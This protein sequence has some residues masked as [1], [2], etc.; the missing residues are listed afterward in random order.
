MEFELLRGFF[1]VLIVTLCFSLFSQERK[2]K[3]AVMEIEDRSG[4][5]SK[6]IL[7]NAAE[8]LRSELAA[9]N[10]YVLISKDRQLKAM[11]KVEKKESY[12]ECYDQ[13]CRIQLG[14]ALSADTVTYSTI[15]IFGGTYTIALEMIDLAKEAT[16]DAAKVEFNGTE[17]GLKT[18]IDGIVAQIVRKK[19]VSTFQEGRTSEKAEDWEVGQGEETIV[20]FKT[21]PAEAVVLVDGRMLC[22]KTPCS[23]MLSQGKHEVTIQKENYQPKVK[24]FDV[25]KGQ[26]ISAELEPDFG[27]LDVVSEPTGI[28]ISLDGRSIG[29]TPLEKQ[30]INPGPHQVQTKDSCY[31]Q[32]A[33]KFVIER[34]KTKKITL[35]MK[36][37]ESAIKV[38]AQDK[39]GNDV[40]AVIMVDGQ[41]TGQTPG[42]FK[43]PICSREIIVKSKAGEYKKALELEEKKVANINAVLKKSGSA[44]AWTKQWGTPLDDSGNSIAIDRSGNIFVA[45]QT[46]GAFEGFVNGGGNCDGTPAAPKPCNDAFLTKYNADGT[47]AWIRQWGTIGNDEAMSVVVDNS[48][49]IYVAGTTWGQIDGCAN[50]GI[51]DIFLSKWNTDGYKEWTKT[52]GSN[53]IDGSMAAAVDAEG[54]IY[55]TGYTNGDLDGNTG[56][57]DFDLFLAKWRSDGSREWTKLLG[58]AASEAGNAITVDKSGNI[59]VA[60]DTAGSFSGFANAGGNCG[61]PNDPQ[62]CEDIFLAKWTPDGNRAW[63]K[64]WGAKGDESV[65]GVNT[66]KS[67]SL[68]VTGSTRGAIDGSKY[69]GGICGD[70][71]CTDIFITKLNGNGTKA[72]TKQFGTNAEEFGNSAS[73]DGSGSIYISGNTGGAFDGHSV[74]GDD[75]CGSEQ[76]PVTCSTTYILKLNAVGAKVWIKQY[77]SD[78]IS[79]TAIDS[80]GNLFV[81][82]TVWGASEDNVSAGGTDI[83]LSKW[84]AK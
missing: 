5:F 44:P 74:T 19:K 83:Y 64:Q 49:N 25:K 8:Y 66:D 84:P 12:K 67:G 55:V 31:F 6:A 21:T 79:S 20:E 62:P 78:A 36:A 7:E 70:L 28:E 24:V 72:W 58:T 65:T 29:K 81:T 54:N 33:E 42:T 80:A 16:V 13:Q 53:G 61:Q 35:D 14:Q 51:T 69:A 23:K 37:K 68:F 45:G 77:G 60:G 43:V 10:K 82:G 26:K 50:A 22:Q 41:E 56:T 27:W 11:I 34:G 46:K 59:F 57:G 15:T 17:K 75:N 4:K 9:T 1:F 71:P 38:N 18:A 48:G 30:E 2:Q 39:D 73:V 40:A 32:I 76:E 3:V 63:V 52:L 47:I